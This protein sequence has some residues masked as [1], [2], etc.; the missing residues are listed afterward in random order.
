MES[1]VPDA[2]SPQH[3]AFDVIPG[4]LPTG[5]PKFPKLLAVGHFDTYSKLLLTAL[6][7]RGFTVFCVTAPNQALALFSEH[8]LQIDIVAIDAITPSSGNLDL[9]AELE[10]LRPGMPMLYVVGPQKT[11]LRS[12]I[13][14]H[15]PQLAL[16]APFTEARLM[17]RIDG[18]LDPKSRI[19]ERPA[20]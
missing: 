7:H 5:E 18:L 4:P 12:S 3:L 1:A 19:A 6:Q 16:V 20:A 11:V 9:A 13:E 8:H 14:A 2:A 15:A 17:E 10:R